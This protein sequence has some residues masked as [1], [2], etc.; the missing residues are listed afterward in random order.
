MGPTSK[1]ELRK[2]KRVELQALAKVRTGTCRLWQIL[3][4]LRLGT[5]AQHQGEPQD[6]SA[7]RDPRYRARAVRTS[8]D[9]EQDI[10]RS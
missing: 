10:S 2:L 9:A 6:G 5:G 8:R 1:D 4:T 7:R 3:L